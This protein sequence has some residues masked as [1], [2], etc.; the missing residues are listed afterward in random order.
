MSV[1][2]LSPQTVQTLHTPLDLELANGP[3]WPDIVRNLRPG[4]HRRGFDISEP[5]CLEWYNESVPEGSGASIPTTR[6][7]TGGETLVILIANSKN[8]WPFFLQACKTDSSLLAVVDPLDSFVEHSIQSAMHTSLPGYKCRYFWSHSQSDE[9]SGNRY[10][11]IQRMAQA[12]GLAYMDPISNL[13]LHPKFGPWIALRCA[14]V[15]EGTQYTGPRKT[16]LVN[17]LSP[18]TEQYVQMAM[19]SAQRQPSMSLEDAGNWDS[20]DCFL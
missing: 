18:S 12:A 9:L 7:S 4:L 1:S 8:M 14:L 16:P 3:E 10:V 6:G 11:A 17:R 20:S 13:C 5:L 19:K 2:V 15:F